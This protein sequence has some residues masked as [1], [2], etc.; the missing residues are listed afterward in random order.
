MSLLVLE[1]MPTLQTLFRLPIWQTLSD[2]L[3]RLA[4]YRPY[5]MLLLGFAVVLALVVTLLTLYHRFQLRHLFDS[6]DRMLDQAIGGKFSPTRYDESRL[7]SVETRIARYLHAQ[8]VATDQLANEKERLQSFI[9]DISHQTKTPI[10]SMLLYAELLQEQDLP[11]ACRESVEALT[12]QGE[13]LRFLMD[14]L[15][16]AGRLEFG[17]ITVQP[18][19]TDLV[20]C[21]EA[22]AEQVQPVATQKGIALVVCGENGEKPIPS[23]L[24]VRFDPK[25]TQE[26]VWNLLDNAIKYTDTGGTVTLSV[27]VYELFCCIVV[28][29]TGR[30]I[31]E[32]EQAQIFERFYRSPSVRNAQG[33]GLGL[34]IVREIVAAQQGYV[35]V[36]SKQGKGSTFSLFL[37]RY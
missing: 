17:I 19:L 11:P 23:P 8:Q 28:R 30:G 35:K 22:A 2:I 29:D 37:P 25:W 27:V 3:A 34:S 33:V 36:A 16:K 5:A 15:V 10:A 20:P 32:T 12:A 7:S 13:R 18:Y 14:S 31:A 24:Q 9:A 1:A 6:I 4:P 26:A 21:L